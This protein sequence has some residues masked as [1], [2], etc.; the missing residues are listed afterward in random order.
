M[1]YDSINN[2]IYSLVILRLWNFLLLLLFY[3]SSSSSY[4]RSSNTTE[5]L[6]NYTPVYLSPF[7]MAPF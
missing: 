5:H 1:T 3:S 4:S 2:Y 6:S 7:L